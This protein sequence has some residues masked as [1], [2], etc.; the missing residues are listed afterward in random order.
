MRC[1]SCAGAPRPPAS[2]S[3]LSLSIPSWHATPYDPGEFDDGKFQSSNVDGAFGAKPASRHSHHSRNP[4]HAGHQFRGFH[5][6]P[7]CCGLPGCLAPCTDLTGYPANGA[8]YFQAFNEI[9]PLLD[10]TTAST[11]LLCWWD[12]SPTGTTTR[13]A[14]RLRMMPTFPRSPLRFRTAGSLQYGSKAGISDGT[15]PEHPSA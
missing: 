7:I 10:M 3:G 2:S 15:F 1:L 8:F 13:L 9:G 11:G 12:F 4:L 5:G 14:A 6:S